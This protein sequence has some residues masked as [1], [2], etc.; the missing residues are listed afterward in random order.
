LPEKKR[1]KGEGVFQT[2]GKIYS[3][4]R[5]PKKECL[6]INGKHRREHRGMEGDVGGF[7]TATSGGVR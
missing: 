3:Y 4:C 2:D 1:E 6:V 7:C 5:N